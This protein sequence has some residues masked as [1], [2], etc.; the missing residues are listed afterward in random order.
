MT[1]Y[2][3]TGCLDL[4]PLSADARYALLS[5]ARAADEVFRFWAPYR[6]H[7]FTVTMFRATA[8]DS[9]RLIPETPFR[10]L[11]LAVRLV[12]QQSEKG[13][14]VNVVNLLRAHAPNA[15]TPDLVK[16]QAHWDS[17]LNGKGN[18]VYQTNERSYN[19]REVFET[20]LYANSF[21]QDP[22]KQPDLAAL[23]TF[24]PTTSL[25]LQLV[26]CQLAIATINL[27]AIVRY[28]TGRA[29]RDLDNPPREEV[30]FGFI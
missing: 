26:V 18:L 4:D 22:K 30:A 27:D 3:P 28:L 21:H 12:F 23:R 6:D 8:P 9:A 11:A 19:P 1:D 24:E 14:F 5:F 2:P 10:S 7:Q 15:F 25:T 20:W 16:V 13:A 17:A 29:A